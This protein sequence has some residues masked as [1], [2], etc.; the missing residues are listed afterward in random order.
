MPSEKSLEYFQ[1]GKEIMDTILGPNQPNKITSDILH[2]IGS[3]FMIH[4]DFAKAYECFQ[5][6]LSMNS[7]IF[8]E[9]SANDDTET[10]YQSIGLAAEMM[11]ND[12]Q[13]KKY[14]TEA[15]KISRKIKFMTGA[16]LGGFVRILDRLSSICK[17]DGEQDEALKYSEEARELKKGR[18]L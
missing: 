1:E 10:V 17:A 16:R 4:G 2:G 9:N 15:V 3:Y 5:D 8:G 11:G 7:A 6:A 18:C 13:A 14:Y 12:R